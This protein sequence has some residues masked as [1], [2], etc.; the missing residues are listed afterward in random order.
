MTN[1]LRLSGIIARP[2]PIEV[3]PKASG[4]CTNDIEIDEEAEQRKAGEEHASGSHE[5][6]RM[7][8][9]PQLDQR[10]IAAA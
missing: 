9:I 4:D 2:A 3:Y 7:T 5:I 6:A 10:V 8:E 1:M